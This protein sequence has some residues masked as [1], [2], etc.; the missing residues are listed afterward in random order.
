MHLSDLDYHAALPLLLRE[1]T[2]Q[3]GICTIPI[4]RLR[5][6]YYYRTSLPSWEYPWTEIEWLINDAIELGDLLFFSD[7]DRWVHRPTADL[8]RLRS[9]YTRKQPI[10]LLWR[11]EQGQ[12]IGDYGEEIVRAAMRRAGFKNVRK[13]YLTHPD[14]KQVDIDGLGYLPNS[15]GRPLTIASEV[16]NRTSE[17]LQTPT[18]YM[19][20]QS[21]YERLK[22]GFEVAQDSGLLPIVFIPVVHRSAY[23]WLD[24]HCALACA[25]LFQWIPD[26]QLA[27]DIK[28]QFRFGNAMFV[29]DPDNPPP[30]VTHT[31]D[32]WFR[33]LPSIMA[34]RGLT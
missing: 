16:K 3:R 4:L 29:P 12:R 20:R 1:I 11:V 30:Q 18:A 25:M 31:I 14:G 34:T 19:E 21:L 5:L 22:R 28:D 33:R 32:A 7:D 15:P 6:Y 13:A 26:Q 2:K 24:Q 23:G 10:E 9:V 17:I 27:K 8:D